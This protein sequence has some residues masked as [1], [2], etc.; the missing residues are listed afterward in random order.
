MNLAV[1]DEL[2][3]RYPSAEYAFVESGGDNLTLTFSPELVDLALFVIDVAGGDK[4]PRKRGIGLIRADLL[5]VNKTDLAPYVGAD[6]G[7]M[8]REGLEVRGGRPVLFT[9]CRHGTGLD[10]VLDHLRAARASWLTG[11]R[12]VPPHSHDTDDQHG[13]AHD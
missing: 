6:L 13:H 2:A 5:I 1:L 11:A 8:A 12:V 7:V 10:A 9:D 4:V 3:A